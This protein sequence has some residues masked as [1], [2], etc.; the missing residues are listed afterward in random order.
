MGFTCN[1][2][3]T[4]NRIL[5]VSGFCR[6]GSPAEQ[7]AKA[8]LLCHSMEEAEAR[9]RVSKKG[10]LLEQAL[11]SLGNCRAHHNINSFSTAKSY[12]PHLLEIPFPSNTA[13][14]MRSSHEFWYKM[15]T[16]APHKHQRHSMADSLGMWSPCGCSYPN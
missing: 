5:S 10:L 6:L 1:W 7:P 12:K 13:V 2:L 15:G 8:F 3:C 4:D 9:Q 16:P 14:A 11:P